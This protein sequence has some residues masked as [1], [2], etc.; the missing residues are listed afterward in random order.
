MTFNPQN[1]TK[2]STITERQGHGNSKSTIHPSPQLINHQSDLL[3]HKI[4]NPVKAK[5]IIYHASEEETYHIQQKTLAGVKQSLNL[6]TS[7]NKSQTWFRIHMFFLQAMS[8]C[9]YQQ[10]TLCF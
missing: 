4:S 9:G 7:N 5:A 1:V 10:E 8:S 3:G 6:Y 2:V